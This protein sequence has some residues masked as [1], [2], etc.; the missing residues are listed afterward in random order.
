MAHGFALF[1]GTAP[2]IIGMSA[3]EAEDLG[4]SSFWVNQDRKS[5]V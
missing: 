5:V 2:E 1:A 4:Y 3:R